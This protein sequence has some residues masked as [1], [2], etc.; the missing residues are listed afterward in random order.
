MFCKFC[1]AQIPDESIYCPECDK[2]LIKTTVDDSTAVSGEKKI[3]RIVNKAKEIIKKPIIWIVIGCFLVLMVVVSVKDSGKCDY[4][5]CGNK[6]VSGS[7]Y[8]Y[9]HKCSVGSCDNSQFIN[10]NY[11]YSHSLTYDEDSVGGG[12]VSSSNL[13]LT[14]SDVYTKYNYTY[15]EGTMRNN[16]NSTVEYVRIKGSFTD[17]SGNVIDTDWTYA[18]GSEGLEPGESCKWKLSVSKD[19]RITKCSV[20]I[21][22]FDY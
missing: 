4:S 6:T 8:C 13:K 1:G 22:D 21:L 20:K 18:V 12:Y 11:C 15:A 16:S 10:S 14:I 17:S 2:A 5:G 3:F 7:D 19:Y 9:S